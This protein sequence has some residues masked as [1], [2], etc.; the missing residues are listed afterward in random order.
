VKL[1]LDHEK[2]SLTDTPRAGIAPNRFRNK[3]YHLRC[4]LRYIEHLGYE[5]TPIDKIS[6]VK[7]RGYGIWFKSIPKKDGTA[8]GNDIVNNGISEV[9]KMYKDMAVRE[10]CISKDQ[11]PET[12][13]LMEVPKDGCNRDIL[14]LEQYKT[15]WSWMWHRWTREKG[16]RENEKQK[17]IIFYNLIGI[18]YN[19]GLRTKEILGLKVGEITPVPSNTMKSKE[20]DLLMIT[21]R[22]SNSKT[23][24]R[25]VVVGPIKKRVERLKAAYKRLGIEHKP[26]DFLLINPERED[27][28][29]YTRERLGQR[30]KLVFRKSGLQDE[31]DALGMKVSLYSSRH[32]WITWRLRYGNT[33]IHLLNPSPCQSSR[34][35]NF[36]N[37]R[38]LWS[39]KS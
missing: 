27:R 28:S 1:Y 35:I 38:D 4:W 20:T 29:T 8:R 15:L 5:D 36:S 7:T 31:I 12:D 21:I 37:R 32:N 6:P 13:R 3:D 26:H 11:V 9:R 10:R 34:Y 23:G 18:L 24:K 30:L 17:R 33:P 22:A 19:T 25:R 14:T 39:Y 16:I 2:Q